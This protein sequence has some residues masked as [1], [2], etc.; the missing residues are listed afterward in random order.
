MRPERYDDLFQ[1]HAKSAGLPRIR[2]HD[3]RHT[4]A[5]LL[6]SLGQ[7]PAACAKYLGHTTEVYLRTYAH[8][9]AEDE[10][11]TAKGLSAL[12]AQAL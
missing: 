8:L 9:Y 10:D 3:L 6:H 2:L 12:Y 1:G 4:T 11:A 5:S 7:P